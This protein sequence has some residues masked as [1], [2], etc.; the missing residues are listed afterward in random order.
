MKSFAMS[1]WALTG[2]LFVSAC[3]AGGG[4]SGDT[5]SGVGGGEVVGGTG[6][7]PAGGNG[8]GLTGG[9]PVGGDPV[10]GSGG[11]PVGGDPVGGDPVGGSGGV[12]GEPVGGEPV[13][14]S[15]GA[16]GEP[17]GGDP[18]G[19]SGG[20][21]G[22]PVGGDPVGGSGGAGGEPPPPGGCEAIL[23]CP[24]GEAC[25]PETGVCEPVGDAPT[26]EEA[27]AALQ[28]CGLAGF[29]DVALCVEGCTAES[30][31]EQ[32]ICV[33]AAGCDE[34]DINT[35]FEGVPDL[36]AEVVC[37]EGEVCNPVN[38][39]CEAIIDAPTCDEACA[40]LNGCGLLPD[41]AVA[42]CVEGCTAE[43]TPEQRFCVV[44]A[45]CD[46]GAV[47]AC[48]DVVAPDL[49]DGV[50]CP[51]GEVCN[52]DTGACQ[53]PADPAACGEVCQQFVDCGLAPPDSQA[54]CVDACVGT[55]TP[56]SVVCAAA[57]GC[58]FEAVNLCF[59]PPDPCAEVACADGERC[60]PDSGQCES[61]P[62]C[63]DD[64]LEEN[65]TQ[66][67]AREVAPGSSY[68]ALQVCAF[69]EDWYVVQLDQ[70]CTLTV[71]I[72]FVHA[73]GD[74]D[75]FVDDGQGNSEISAGTDDFE[76]VSYTADATGPHYIGIYGFDGA[77]NA[78]S[79]NVAVAC[80]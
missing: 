69:D 78:Y 51:D 23:E 21:G 59:V 64:E 36:C 11:A 29:E 14:G 8:G 6:G 66:E 41:E 22:E 40:A 35:C 73:N 33:V 43:S 45:G 27:C 3:G 55:W 7:E 52:P 31:P 39:A 15:G 38:G 60:N 34:A 25:N 20:A 57:A 63:A 46:Q 49:C 12:G 76:E 1:C 58:D 47:D 71:R 28:A 13:G 2:A 53:A 16:G 37:G 67:T 42:G 79:M 32:R 44:A 50:V 48:F 4:E 26:C 17:V 56:E 70:G 62:M 72:E 77:L 80:P 75:M 10:G 74:V 68:E 5:D 54:D 65:D 19:G 9:T 18:V 24:E 61:L 30:T